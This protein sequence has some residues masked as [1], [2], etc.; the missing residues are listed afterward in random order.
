MYFS[1]WRRRA[2]LRRM[3]TYSIPLHF[4]NFSKAKTF[5][6]PNLLSFSP[7][8]AQEMSFSRELPALEMSFPLLSKPPYLKCTLN[9]SRGF[10]FWFISTQTL[11]SHTIIALY[12]CFH[13]QRVHLFHNKGLCRI[14]YK[15]IAIE[16]VLC[17]CVSCLHMNGLYELVHRKCLICSYYLLVSQS[18]YQMFVLIYVNIM[19]YLF[20]IKQ[21]RTQH[22]WRIIGD[23]IIACDYPRKE[24]Y[25]QYISSL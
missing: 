22:G 8:V 19:Y 16:N 14:L 11:E 25:T 18:N 23:N 13:I 7:S 6:P 2:N 5:P 1:N 12:I 3:A 4:C 9:P 21:N 20:S 10:S 24:L 15:L 17:H